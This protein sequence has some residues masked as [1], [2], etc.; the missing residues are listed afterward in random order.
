MKEARKSSSTNPS[1]LSPAEHEATPHIS[2]LDDTMNE[3]YVVE[4]PG[5]PL[6]T[7]TGSAL[8][9][10][11]LRE[12]APEHMPQGP[13][14]MN[15]DDGKLITRSEGQLSDSG[16]D[17]RSPHQE[18]ASPDAQYDRVPPL[19]FYF[20]ESKG[21][22]SPDPPVFNC[23]TELRPPARMEASNRF[24]RWTGNTK[25][26]KQTHAVIFNIV[27]G[28]SLTNLNMDCIESFAFSFGPG[29]AHSYGPLEIIERA[30]LLRL[31]RSHSGTFRWSLHHQH[32]EW[33][34]AGSS[35]TVEMEI[36]STNGNSRTQYPGFV[37]LHYMELDVYQIQH[38]NDPTTEAHQPF[39]W[40]IDVAHKAGYM[41]E[42]ATLRSANIIHHTISGDGKYAAT[43][44]ALDSYL[45]LDLWELESVTADP[46]CHEYSDLN[47]EPLEPF[48]P[49]LC[50]QVRWPL[51]SKVYSGCKSFV[52]SISWNASVI[53][54]MSDSTRYLGDTLFIFRH[55]KAMGLQPEKDTTPSPVSKLVPFESNHTFTQMRASCKSGKFHIISHRGQDI[56]DELFVVCNGVSVAIYSIYG[57]WNHVRTIQLLEIDP[58]KYVGPA[59]HRKLIDGIRAKYFS[60][61]DS[62][63]TLLVCNLET[64]LLVSRIPESRNAHF[65]SD[66][67]LLAV[68]H[69]GNVIS[70]RWTEHGV[71][72]A[73]MDGARSN[74]AFVADSLSDILLPLSPPDEMFGRGQ[75]GILMDA[76]TLSVAG[77][78]RVSTPFLL[79]EGQQ[80]RFKTIHG[81]HYIYYGYGSKLSLVGLDAISVKP[82]RMTTGTCDERCFEQQSLIQDRIIPGAESKCTFDMPSGLT[83]GVT[84]PTT[85][86]DEWSQG[87][88]RQSIS[89]SVSNGQAV[90][91]EA[92][93]IPAAVIGVI[94][95]E[96]LEYKVAFNPAKQE[97]I[98]YS[99]VL[100]MVWGL[101]TIL[102]GPFNLLLTWWTQLIPFQV[103]TRPDWYWTSVTQCPHGQCYLS[104]T[105]MDSNHDDVVV[106]MML[107][108]SADAFSFTNSIQFL[109]GILALIEVFGS[110][111]EVFKGKIIHYVGHH[112]NTYPHPDNL[113]ESVLTKICQSVTQSSYSKYAAFLEVLLD[114]PHGR[115]VPRPDF[116][117]STN[118]IC[119]LL[120][121]AEKMPRVIDLVHVL[122]HY[123][124][125]M[126]S[127]EKDLLFVLPLMSPL[128]RLLK[129]KQ[130]YSK[131]AGSLLQGLA[132]IP[133]KERAY[134]IDHHF[135]AHPPGLRLKF[136]KPNQQKLYECKNPVLQ[137]D[138]DPLS[139]DP[140]P[141]NDNFTSDLF[142]ASFDML[143]QAP[144]PSYESGAQDLQATQSVVSM[145]FHMIK[146]NLKLKNRTSIRFNDFAL[147][148]LNNPAIVA[149][150]EYKWN[151]IG[152]TYWL[153]RFFFQCIYYL[154][155][156]TAVFTQ[157]YSSSQGSSLFGVFVAIIVLS[158]VF[159]WFELVQLA[160]NWQRFLSSPY[161]YADV[162]TFALPLA[163]SILQ[164][165]NITNERQD[166]QVYLLSFSVLFI[167]I[168][169]GGRYDSVT[170]EFD[171]QEWSFHV[172]MIIYFFFTA[173]LLLNVLIALINVAFEVGDN[174]W[175]LVWLENRLAYV[176]SAENM[177]YHIPG[178]RQANN[179][180]PSEIYYSSTISQVRDYQA[181]HLNDDEGAGAP[182]GLFGQDS[183]AI[184][185]P[186][187]AAN[188]FAAILTL[189]QEREAKDKE[190]QQ[191]VIDSMRKELQLSQAHLTALQSQVREQQQSFEAQIREL[192]LADATEVRE[193][194][195]L[196]V[197]VLER[198]PK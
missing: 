114:S 125:R 152:F 160:H 136:W 1:P 6:A 53:A 74:P 117:D 181:K 10:Q 45:Q 188:K 198:E 33:K 79:Q 84:F 13:S 167:F 193:L 118:P 32:L 133:A 138:R 155:V 73:F 67:T 69:Q 111:D 64:G 61:T 81:R 196:L 57:Q 128:H 47:T 127:K 110:A 187:S 63:G 26:A 180:F 105:E 161:N 121:L 5:D 183:K 144:N 40:S 16:C 194:K 86:T 151:T 99:D 43:I 11:Q 35:F 91:P 158:V 89:I 88:G 162:A 87:S 189:H 97:M 68:R 163:G 44:S 46:M 17:H 41:C 21:Q 24:T 52:V 80:F 22:T 122:I 134:I 176:A 149:L 159:L 120:E 185:A 154:L 8:S 19:R 37:E 165:F 72:V 27:L 9:T 169:F 31:S 75:L 76:S 116:E 143:W 4:I 3:D 101:P 102:H 50:T 108:H 66:G 65:S 140:N 130:L 135:I 96:R 90:L 132:F 119:I 28:L 170:D 103:N 95:V 184:A 106:D 30:E 100:V 146:L 29:A 93:R 23:T 14:T 77:S 156:L 186:D 82:Y 48:Y 104:V 58:E 179:W 178:F 175:R 139:K 147:E 71:A 124:T 166:G 60:W 94:P 107:L 129:Q 85:P 153:Y 7:S 172:M 113:L 54:L 109:D 36:R 12:P 42:R 126:A 174:N 177:T 62:Q 148:S 55:E 92:L 38:S 195:N 164:L 49:V 18:S 51:K 191:A 142:V 157:V 34:P 168:H 173:I 131:V 115:W 182:H 137:L 2:K 112:L 39:R 78:D 192:K 145:I 141:R 150:V 56:K 25:Q 171:E 98:I 20:E 59:I 83:F 70:T 15:Y 190:F 197:S 123:C